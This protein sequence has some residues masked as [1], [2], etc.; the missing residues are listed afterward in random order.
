MGWH[1]R[2]IIVVGVA[3]ALALPGGEAA[4][5]IRRPSD[6]SAVNLPEA[7]AGIGGRGLLA[8]AGSCPADPLGIAQD[9]SLFV[10]GT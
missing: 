1:S 9:F 5:A 8:Q 2:I 10:L 7:G 4:A 6:A 3:I